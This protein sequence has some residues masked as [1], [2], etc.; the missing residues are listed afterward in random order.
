MS[1]TPRPTPHSPLPT[2]CIVGVDTGGTFTDI[3]IRGVDGS[4]TVRKLPSTPHDPSQSV[5]Q[6]IAEALREGLIQPPFSVAHGTTVATNAL[7][8]ERGARAALITTQGFR[9]VLEIGRQTRSQ[10]YTFH[11]TKPAPLIAQSARFELRERLDWQGRV[12]V[13]LEEAETATL[14]DELKAQGYESLAVCFLFSYLN[15]VHERLV[16]RLARER[17]LPTSLSCD[18]APEPREYERT[19]TT[20]ANAFVAPIMAQYLSNLETR[21]REMGGTHLRVMQSDGGALSPEEASRRAISTALSGPAGGIVAAIQAGSEAG[22]PDLLTF[23]MGGTSTD[24]ALIHGGQCAIVTNGVLGD[25]PLRAPMLDI[26]T[27]GAGGGSLARIDRAGGL[28][29]GP[30]SAGADPGPVA[31]GKGE[32]LT[33]T[34]A[35]ILLGRLPDDLRLAGR[36]PLDGARVRAYF[37]EFAAQLQCSPEQA[38]VGILDV[39]N[40]TMTRALR[41]VSVERGHD[42]S[43]LALLSFGGAGGLHAC[44]LARALGMTRVLIPRFPGAFS[45]LG[46][47]LANARREYGQAVT[48]LRLDPADLHNPARL[49]EPIQKSLRER[50]EQDMAREGLAAEEWQAQTLLDMRCVGQSFELRVPVLSPQTPDTLTAAIAAFHALHA[51]RFGYADTREPV[52]ITAIRLIAIG[53]QSLP[54]T[55]SPVLDSHSVLSSD[56]MQTLENAQP[57]ATPVAIK[58]NDTRRAYV[59]SDWQDVSL[60]LRPALSIG[61][62]IAGPALIVQEDAATYIAPGWQAQTDLN[63]N[64]LL[65]YSPSV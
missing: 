61:Q 43:R 25:I 55:P 23:D 50:A 65:I 62:R 41:H 47:A 46:L 19:S 22:F 52:Q 29:V 13:P 57:S 34:D 6:G 49:L 36:L 38:A 10:L 5:L 4:L 64:L 16:E 54:Q 18:V 33:V 45:A 14:L 9:D 60:H 17:G 42:P 15:P 8:Q 30:Q 26:H 48:P 7:L 58:A 59:E 37:A 31:Y 20:V 39:A 53:T 63:Y 12:L 56:A 2:P 40:A 21:L 51:Q 1:E 27:V 44:A 3:V 32:V 35:N 28:R 24:A 11:P